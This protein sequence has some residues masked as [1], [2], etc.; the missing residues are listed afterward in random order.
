VIEAA[1]AGLDQIQ[2]S[3]LSSYVLP[4]EVEHL[5]VIGTLGLFGTGNALANKL[6]GGEGAD[7]L[8]G[9]GG[10]DHLNGGAGA[11]TLEGGEGNDQIFGGTEADLVLG[12]AGND[13]L[14]GGFGADTVEGGEDSDDIDGEAGDDLLRGGAG[15]DVIRGDAGADTLLGG[16]GADRLLGGMGG[17]VFV[18]ASAAEGGDTIIGYANEDR[19]EVSAAGF[20]GGLVA[21]RALVLNQD[22]I[23]N[24]TG[25]ANAL[26]GAGQFIYETDSRVLRWDA[27]GQGGMAAVVIATFVVPVGFGIGEI[28]VIA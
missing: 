16:L 26:N 6:Q 12:G 14:R 3:G 25:L 20:G 19:I 15:N 27:D 13:V 1:G 8:L 9:L 21:S 23:E 24:T 2:V 7:R 22:Y 4:A 28:S 5:R 18:Y 10:T 17:D 11:D